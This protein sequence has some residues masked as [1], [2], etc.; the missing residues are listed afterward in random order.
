MSSKN[1]EIKKIVILGAGPTAIGALYQ[2]FE[3]QKEGLLEV[4]FIF[5]YKNN[6]KFCKIMLNLFKYKWNTLVSILLIVYL[7]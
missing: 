6:Y 7:T 1:N 2:I 5:Y 4:S 3:L